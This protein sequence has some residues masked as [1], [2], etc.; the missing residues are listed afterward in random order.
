V[1]SQ[2]VKLTG[3]NTASFTRN[4]SGLVI[5]TTL[6]SDAGGLA[7]L[8]LENSSEPTEVPISGL[9]HTGQGELVAARHVD[10]EEFLL[11]YNIDGC[12][13]LYQA[14]LHHRRTLNMEAEN[15]ICGLP[16]LSDGVLQGYE[17]ELSDRKQKSRVEHVFSFTKA[18]TP[19]Q[20]L[21]GKG[22]SS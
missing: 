18:T 9:K 2:P 4:D 3:F 11:E 22:S 10:E 7:Y 15:V 1:S 21:L 16:P 19:S 13:W 14:Q 8:P 5:K 12:S 20:M 17:F 6:F